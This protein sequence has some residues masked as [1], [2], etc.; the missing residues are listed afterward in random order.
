MKLDIG[1]TL[2]DST[3]LLDMSLD[4]IKKPIII[5]KPVI[6][7]KKRKKKTLLQQ[8]ESTIPKVS[9]YETVTV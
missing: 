3:G 4:D 2:S 6:K 5:K 9:E 8:V 1:I 7:K